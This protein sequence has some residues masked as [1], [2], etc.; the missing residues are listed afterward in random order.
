MPDQR[1][2]LTLPFFGVPMTGHPELMRRAE[3]AGYEDL[4]SSE[5]AAADGFTPLALAAV[6][7]TTMRLATGVVNPYTRGP[8]VLAQH[9]AALA[10][11]S[12]GRFVLGLGSSSDVIVERWNGIPFERPLRRM[13][14]AI[15]TL[16]PILA[17]ERG[18]GG[19]RLDMPPAEP[20][21]IVVAALRGRMLAL[22]AELGDGGFTN[23][24]PLSGTA[25]V[26]EA[27]GAPGKELACRYFSFPG[28]EDEALAAARRMLLAYATVP[29]YSAF[30]EWL[31]WGERL[32]ADARRVERGRPRARARADA[33]RPRARGRPARAAG[34]PARADR[35]VRGGRDHDARD[36]PDGG[37]RGL[38][39]AARR[40]QPPGMSTCS[41]SARWPNSSRAARSS[42]CC[43]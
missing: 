27:F 9:A 36:H 7:T 34:G 29:V 16:R 42:R 13:R 37:S 33:R 1:F 26:V 28:P 39:G 5:V 25:Q 30:Y 15:E 18:P 21:P 23:L 22:A 12:G 38:P 35:R 14:E 40:A 3:A 31:G 20:V 8:A 32:G 10:D 43:G 6:H 24:L 41:S 2:G 19:F 17:G 11:A 4:W